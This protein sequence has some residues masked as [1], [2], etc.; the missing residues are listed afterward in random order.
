MWMVALKMK[1]LLK[2]T[3]GHFVSLGFV[4]GRP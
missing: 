2:K 3:A 1:S 4:P